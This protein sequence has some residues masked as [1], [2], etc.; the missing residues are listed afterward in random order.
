MLAGGNATQ[1]PLE[2][3]GI[4]LCANVTT[5]RHSAYTPNGCACCRQFAYRARDQLNYR[6]LA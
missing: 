1:K 2:V 3:R 5:T 4:C 6:K